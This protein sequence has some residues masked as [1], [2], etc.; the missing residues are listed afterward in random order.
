MHVLSAPQPF[1]WVQV[2]RCSIISLKNPTLSFLIIW[3]SSRWLTW[4]RIPSDHHSCS[5]DR[6]V[7]RSCPLKTGLIHLNHS[8]RLSEPSLNLTTQKLERLPAIGPSSDNNNNVLM[9]L[10][11]TNYA[12][13]EGPPCLLP[14]HIVLKAQINCETEPHA[15]RLAYT[16]WFVRQVLLRHLYFFIKV[17][18]YNLSKKVQVMQGMQK[19][20]TLFVAFWN[21][22]WPFL[23][24]EIQIALAWLPPLVTPS[25]IPNDSL[26]SYS[27]DRNSRGAWIVGMG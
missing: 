16:I 13:I 11:S 23:I 17:I 10:S 12:F 5:L 18:I 7:E 8:G 26:C 27:P 9:F 21:I 24:Y 20:F 19:I 3:G 25:T 22:D 15:T 2:S 4:K 1:P 14:V 6:G